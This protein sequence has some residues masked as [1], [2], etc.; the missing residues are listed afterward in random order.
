M[1]FSYEPTLSG[2]L[3]YTLPWH[4][5]F[6]YGKY[7][8]HLILFGLLK[9]THNNKINL[10]AFVILLSFNKHIIVGFKYSF[11]TNLLNNYYM[12]A[13]SQY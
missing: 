12:S 4:L 11:H 2:L 8:K 3:L 5:I 13:L 7:L 6:H 10:V 1:E 9:R